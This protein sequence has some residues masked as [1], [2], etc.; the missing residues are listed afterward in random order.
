MPV[1]RFFIV[2]KSG[3]LIYSYDNSPVYPSVEQTLGY[4]LPFELEAVE[5]KIEVTYGEQ[6]GIK[7]GQILL[8]YNE[9]EVSGTSVRDGSQTGT[10]VLTLLADKANYPV[11]L[12]FGVPKMTSNEK[13]IMASTFHTVFAFS[14]QLSPQP[15]SSGIKSMDLG[16]YKFFCFQSPTGTKFICQTD[17]KVTDERA[18]AFLEKCYEIY[19][20]YALKNPFYSLE[21]PIRADL[22]DIHL[23][24]SIELIDRP[25][26][27]S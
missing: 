21:M 26:M 13:I 7:T 24:S 16:S 6:D 19:S 25:L 3:G 12:R 20:D 11:N 2:S 18:D 14:C 9:H 22:F 10:P 15:G 1:D 27:R 4:P 17:P 8:N 23:K 5:G